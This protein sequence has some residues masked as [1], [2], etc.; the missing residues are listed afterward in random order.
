MK[1]VASILLLAAVVVATS[2]AATT[3][4]SATTTAANGAKAAAASV[5]PQLTPKQQVSFFETI[6]I[7]FTTI[8][9][10]ET[11]WFF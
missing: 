9:K 1:S 2:E 10:D 6:F 4:S 11:Y 3:P 8:I 7:Y 5:W